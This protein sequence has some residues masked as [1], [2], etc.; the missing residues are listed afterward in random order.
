MSKDG[1]AKNNLNFVFITEN[2]DQ[3]IRYMI[4]K[5]IFEKIIA[6]MEKWFI[7]GSVE[8]SCILSCFNR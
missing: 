8:N 3:E 6:S 1:N 2:T 4:K 7:G 5:M